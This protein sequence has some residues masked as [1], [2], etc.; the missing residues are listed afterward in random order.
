MT[1]IEDVKKMKVQVC[2]AYPVLPLSIS[3][4][5]CPVIKQDIRVQ[6][7]K[8][9]LEKRDL[10]TT[11]LKAELLDRLMDSMGGDAAGDGDVAAGEA[12][13]PVQV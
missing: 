12:D 6:D 10:P 13:L 3:L 4:L 11:G 9:E 2:A 8:D 5:F 1:T 7:L